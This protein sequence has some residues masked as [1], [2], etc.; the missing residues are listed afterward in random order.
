MY[1][2]I[3]GEKAE[4]IQLVDWMGDTPDLNKKGKQ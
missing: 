4:K 1:S 2:K 3:E